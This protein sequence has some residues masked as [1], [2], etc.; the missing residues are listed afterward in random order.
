MST[1]LLLFLTA[2]ASS[3]IAMNDVALASATGDVLEIET[4]PMNPDDDPSLELEFPEAEQAL[5]RQNRA[6]LCRK[7]S[8]A[9][10]GTLAGLAALIM[11][12][13]WGLRNDDDLYGPAVGPIGKSPSAI[14]CAG[15]LE[16]EDELIKTYEMRHTLVPGTNLEAWYLRDPLEDGAQD[17]LK[18]EKM[19]WGD[20]EYDICKQG[21][22]EWEPLEDVHLES[23]YRVSNDYPEKVT[24]YKGQ[25]PQDGSNFQ[26]NFN[27]D[28][29]EVELIIE[30]NNVW[31][32]QI[33]P[34]Q[35]EAD[36]YTLIFPASTNEAGEANGLQFA[37]FQMPNEVYRLCVATNDKTTDVSSLD[38]LDRAVVGSAISIAYSEQVLEHQRLRRRH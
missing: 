20:E 11:G 36:T 4:P 28:T 1:L 13:R 12:L 33:Q 23:S 32:G 31:Q 22:I 15:L 5:A 30:E 2:L 25:L 34:V 8:I 35:G 17:K 7:A 38:E 19:V 37:T 27:H 26:I 14:S 3:T 29:K 16:V 21:E 9:V 24:T 10:V 6:K 18:F